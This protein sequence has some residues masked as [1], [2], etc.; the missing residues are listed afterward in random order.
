[1]TITFDKFP[2]LQRG[3]DCEGSD[4]RV[5]GQVVGYIQRVISFPRAGGS[6]RTQPRG[7]VTGYRVY[8]GPGDHGRKLDSLDG[9]STEVDFKTLHETRKAIIAAL[10]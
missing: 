5:D 1:M 6:S 7:T 8:P 10:G 2:P 3:E 9:D 4:I